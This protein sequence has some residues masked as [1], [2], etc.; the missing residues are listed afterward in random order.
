MNIHT[1]TLGED[2]LLAL[3]RNDS[4]EIETDGRMVVY[5]T[6]QIFPAHEVPAGIPQVL[7]SDSMMKELREQGGT[8]RVP[9]NSPYVFS[10]QVRR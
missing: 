3:E 7:V 8:G 6:R 5:L 9:N 2:D 4:V 1:I 10:F